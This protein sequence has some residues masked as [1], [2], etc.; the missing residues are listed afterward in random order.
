MRTAK[1]IAWSFVV[2]WL[3]V[4]LYCSRDREFLIREIFVK[5]KKIDEKEGVASV[6]PFLPLSVHTEL[7]SVKSC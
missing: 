6:T 4:F 3:Q 1:A 7:F 5:K 2:E